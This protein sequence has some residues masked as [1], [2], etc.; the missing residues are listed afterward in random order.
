MEGKTLA[1]RYLDSIMVTGYKINSLEYL[2][3]G[4]MEES[5]EIIGK[6]KRYLRGDYSKEEFKNQMG[7]EI[8]DLCWYLV[9]YSGKNGYKIK[10]FAK[11]RSTKLKDNL[12]NIILLN[13]KLSAATNQRHRQ[14]IVNSMLNCSINLAWNFGLTMEDI[15]R[16]NIDK[17][18]RRLINNTIK[19]QGDER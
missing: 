9:L 15:C 13:G 19:G 7:K 16:A 12:N 2:R 4:I 10:D 17:T 11:P 5:G 1:E 8:G 14:V 18:H 6:A 3:L